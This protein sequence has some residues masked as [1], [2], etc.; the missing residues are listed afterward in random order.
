M[1]NFLMILIFAVMPAV[2]CI[3]IMIYTTK[4]VWR[5]LD[6]FDRKDHTK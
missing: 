3:G 6:R 1:W 2:G 4:I 5:M